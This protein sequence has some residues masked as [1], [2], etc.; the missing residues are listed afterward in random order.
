MRAF[1][2]PLAFA[3]FSITGGTLLADVITLE[4]GD[5]IRGDVVSQDN[6]HLWI[7][8]GSQVI[9]VQRSQV[10]EHEMTAQEEGGQTVRRFLF[11]VDDD[12]TELSIEQQA[13]LVKPSVIKVQTPAGLG[14]GVIINEDGYAITNAHVIQGE[15]N[16]RATIWLPVEGG[17][18]RRTTLEDV[19][20]VAV[21]NHLDLALLKFTH[22]DGE[23]FPYS[24][25][26]WD[27]GI[28]VGQPVFAIGNPLGLEQTTSDG[29]VSTTQRNFQGL[30][31]IQTN[32][33]INPGN[34]GGPLFNTRGEVIGI[35]NMGIL[36]GEGLNFAIPTRYVKDFIRNREA[37]T[38]DTKNPNSGHNYHV[39]PARKNTG[40]ADEL[41]N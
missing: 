14:S 25:L 30:T 9:K 26:E 7:R 24:P 33:A 18:T 39:P 20:I 37:F 19:E 2:A 40:V 23:A 13:N 29:V 6:A 11:H 10:I 1:L 16:L 28:M 27:E 21:N 32:T 12:P 15:T 31:Y 4:G 3:I 35:T 5:E 38:Y 22:P 34:S 17:K 36:A 41:K 8:V